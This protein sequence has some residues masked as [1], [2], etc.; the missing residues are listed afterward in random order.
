M[1]EF[2]EWYSEIG[3]AKL[4]NNNAQADQEISHYPE[5]YIFLYSQQLSAQQSIGIGTVL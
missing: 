5:V 3:P 2:S 4:T 1:F